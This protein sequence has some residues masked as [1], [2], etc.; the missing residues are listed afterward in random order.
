MRTDWLDI[1][2]SDRVLLSLFAPVVTLLFGAFVFGCFM[3]HPKDT[4][5][6]V[7]KYVLLEV[8][9][10]ATL[11]GGLVSLWVIARPC[12]VGRLL[13]KRLLRTL[14]FLIFL[15][16]LMVVFMLLATKF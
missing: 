12:W 9:S 10:M 8:F 11:F 5:S 7:M 13:R 2:I 3:W 1:G 15:G 16:P 6:V 14:L 4:L